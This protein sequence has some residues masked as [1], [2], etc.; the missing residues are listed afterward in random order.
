MKSD[1]ELFEL[2]KNYAH[3]ES[4]FQTVATEFEIEEVKEAMEKILSTLLEK[5]Y[6]ADKFV[7]YKKMYKD[8]TIGE[9]FEFIKKFEQEM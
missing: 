4:L 8:M 2:A 3:L 5:R 9:Y 7:Q 1:K 6:S